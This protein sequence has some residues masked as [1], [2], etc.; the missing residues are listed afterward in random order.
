MVKEIRVN[1][2]KIEFEDD[3]LGATRTL[4]QLSDGTYITNRLASKIITATRDLA[5]ASGD[6][7]YPGVGFVPTSILCIAN[8]DNSFKFSIGMVD[9]SRVSKSIAPSAANFMWAGSTF[10]TVSNAVDTAQTAIL[11]SF[12]ADG[13]VLTWTKLG[14]PTGTLQLSFLCFR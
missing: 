1:A 10:I 8:V 6:V 5:A 14:S 7:N 3:E 9:V 11:K 12:E 13:F 2:T 4:K